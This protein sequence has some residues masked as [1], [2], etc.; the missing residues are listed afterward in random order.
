M[1]RYF[2][3]LREACNLVVTA[4][5][6]ALAPPAS[7]ASVYVLNMGPPIK[8]VDLAERIIRL[9]GL[10]P[11]KDI[12]IVFT[13]IRPGERLKEIEFAD[14]EP[15]VDIGIA[16][17]RAARPLSPTLDTVRAWLATLEQ[18]L[19]RNDRDAIYRALQ[20]A[21]PGFRKEAV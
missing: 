18:A 6:H 3:D 2:I 20:D 14:D 16:G 21:V 12:E 8:I 1:L 5:S 15:L 9:Y 7:D 11:G 10:E 17:V 13:G 19:R 4:A